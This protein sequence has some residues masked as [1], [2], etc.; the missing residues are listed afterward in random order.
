MSHIAEEYAKSLGVKIGYPVLR[1]HFFPLV[2]DKYVT[3]QTA[4][5]FEARNYSFWDYTVS[6]LRSYIPDYD[7]V[8]V[9]ENE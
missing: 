5:K 6:L 7:I 8:Q 1:S 9:S 2:S 4:K 3:L